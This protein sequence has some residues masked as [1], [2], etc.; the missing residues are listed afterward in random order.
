MR[1]LPLMGVLM[2]V[3]CIRSPGSQPMQ[4]EEDKSI[5]FP[6][7]FGVEGTTVGEP[8]KL[9]ELDGATLQALMIAVNDFLPSNSKERPC[10]SNPL[11]HRYR[12]V[13]RENIIFVQIYADTES[14]ERGFMMMDYGVKY[15]ISTDGHILRRLFSGDP[16]DSLDATPMEPTDAGLPPG[17]D[18]SSVLGATWGSSEIALP[19]SWLDGG[20]QPDGGSLPSPSR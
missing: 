19:L 14:C 20:I 7:F 1:Y 18:M 10:W 16:G 17:K 15:A 5:V 3:H 9:Y 4:P 6:Q 12:V 8:G 11:G 13:R 2:L